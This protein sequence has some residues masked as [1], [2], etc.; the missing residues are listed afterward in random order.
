MEAALFWTLLV[1]GL[2]P[3]L[4]YPVLAWL[5]GG[6]TNRRVTKDPAFLPRVTVIIAAY[7]EARHIEATVRNK[8]AQD[9]PR[10]LLQILVVSDGSTDGTD[11]IV[12]RIAAE[13]DRLRLL[14]QTPRQGKTVGLNRA[15]SQ[16]AGEI[17][18][19]SDAN[20]L[21]RPDALR[22]LMRNFADREVG[23]V[24]GQ[25]LYANTDGSLVGDGCTAYMRYENALRAVETRL[26]SIVG[27]DGAIDSVRRSLYRPM[28]PDQLPDFV[29]PLDVAEQGYRVVYE[30]EAIVTEEALSDESA[31]YRMRVRVA[32]RALWAL[33]DKRRLL[34]PL[35]YPLFSWQ[36]ASHKLL[37]YL[38]AGPLLLAA[39]MNW[40]LLGHG[41]IYQLAAV[42][43][44]AFFVL[45]ACKVAGL[46][47]LANLAITR[48]CYYFFLLNWSSAV[49]FLKFLGG[50]RQVL[51]Q[52]RTG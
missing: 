34:N 33:W 40:Y 50:T 52:P 37:R 30:A 44:V 6:L 45:I 12:G 31:E 14:Q 28:R 39:A 24:S 17:L 26:G 32:L 25:M 15:A 41:V 4:V 11:Q 29:L 8:L 51:W 46:R 13:D 23:Y 35:R 42:C 7:N 48:Y 43:Q 22:M 19:F 47:P 3:Y 1:I 2:Y 20:S 10:D 16:A 18:V 9:Y 5:V 21:Y 38:S 36:L 27:V 49:A